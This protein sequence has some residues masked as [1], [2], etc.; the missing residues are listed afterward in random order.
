M[1]VSVLAALS[2]AKLGAAASPVA[3]RA[4]IGHKRRDFPLGQRLGQSTRLAN[5]TSLTA[6]ARVGSDV[7]EQ[8]PTGPQARGSPRRRTGKP[9]RRR[10]TRVYSNNPRKPA[11]CRGIVAG[12]HPRAAVIGTTTPPVPV[13][14]PSQAR[15]SNT[16]SDATA[17]NARS[18]CWQNRK[19]EQVVG[20]RLSRRPCEAPRRQMTQ[21]SVG[22][23]NIRASPASTCPSAVTA[24]ATTSGH[25]ETEGPT[26]S[27]FTPAPVG[28]GFPRPM[29]RRPP[30]AG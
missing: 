1:R 12:A 28:V 4:Q 30:R 29:A 18:R 7:T 3:G 21:E 8:S 23:F 25:L 27:L 15:K 11:I 16:S 2:P 17:D 13:R 14:R 5:Q 22:Q 20:V 19:K 10:Q 6:S 9:T 26:S 24:P